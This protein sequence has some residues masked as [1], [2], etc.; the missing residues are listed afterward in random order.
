MSPA[1]LCCIGVLAS[2]DASQHVL[3]LHRGDRVLV[4][5]IDA[6]DAHITVRHP[7]FGEIAVPLDDIASLKQAP[8]PPRSSGVTLLEDDQPVNGQ[9]DAPASEPPA[10]APS[11]AT[12]PPAVDTAGRSPYAGRPPEPPPASPAPTQVP[13]PKAPAAPWKGRLGAAF[14]GS[15]TTQTTYNL[16]LSGRLHRTTPESKTDLSVTYY[17][18]SA[19]GELTDNDLLARG[20]QNWLD[21]DSIWE[22][23]VQSTYQYDEFE[24]W[25][26]RLS[27]YGG[28]GMQLIKEDDLKLSVKGGGGMTWEQGAGIVRPQAILEVESTWKIDDQQ[29]IAGYSSIAPDVENPSD[30]L[31]TIKWDWRMQ[32]SKESPLALNIGVREIY[33]STPGAGANHSDFKLWAGIT[34]DF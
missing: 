23:F 16:R 11:D 9:E 7:L 32:L 20:E 18:N 10:A 5:V 1:L 6:D 14:T 31:A 33:D 19:D 3:T 27:P 22:V 12:A 26:H 13:A 30:F 25:A 21:P 24:A 2:A 4:E 17:L 34:W 28:V 8:R 29:S 15:H